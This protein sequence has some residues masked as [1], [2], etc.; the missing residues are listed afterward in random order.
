MDLNNNDRIILTAK[1]GKGAFLE[2]LDQVGENQILLGISDKSENPKS[3]SKEKTLGLYFRDKKDEKTRIGLTSSSPNDNLFM[4]TDGFGNALFDVSTF[5]EMQGRTTSCVIGNRS[6][7]NLSLSAGP[8]IS[9][10]SLSTLTSRITMKN[11]QDNLPM[12]YKDKFDNSA[13]KKI[14]F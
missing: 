12:L 1:N 10:A 11:E 3:T 14:E 8:K 2:L 4:I 5:P 13:I 6:D 7:G 9:V